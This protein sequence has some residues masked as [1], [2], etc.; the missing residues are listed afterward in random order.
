MKARHWNVVG[1]L[2][3]T[4]NGESITATSN[5]PANASNVTKSLRT[6]LF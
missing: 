6:A 1:R 4:S 5:A 3:N 2:T